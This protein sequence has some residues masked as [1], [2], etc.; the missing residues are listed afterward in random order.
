MKKRLILTGFA[1]MV[2]GIA[3]TSLGFR[4]LTPQNVQA[5]APAPA[6]DAAKAKAK[7]KQ[8]VSTVPCGP[9]IEGDLGKNTAKDS[10]CFE[11][12][13]YTVDP[14]RDGV[15]QFKGGITELHKRFRE[16]ELEVLRRTAWT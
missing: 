7:G 5:Q 13:F 3:I 10:R 9:N 11:V 6:A 1:G 16:G 14:T 15:G 4:L 2:A 12:R 8:A